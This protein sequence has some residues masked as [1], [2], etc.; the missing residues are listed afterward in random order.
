M[1]VTLWLATGDLDLA[2]ECVDEACARALARWERVSVMDSPSG[3]VY[4]VALNHA[5]RLSRRRLLERSLLPRMLAPTII[6]PDASETWELV[7]SLP[8]RQRQVVVMRH[9]GNLKEAD[10]AQTLHIS[11]STVSTTLRDAHKKLGEVL[12]DSTHVPVNEVKEI[13]D[14]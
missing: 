14:V 3:W 8:E 7:A 2:S 12:R 11:R 4:S 1:I 6:S 9:V 10:I 13:T 5:R